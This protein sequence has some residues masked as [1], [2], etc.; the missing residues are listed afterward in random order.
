MQYEEMLS[1]LLYYVTLFQVDKS[2][3]IEIADPV[4]LV[5]SQAIHSAI[6]AFASC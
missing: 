4:G 3:A 6:A 5:Q 1:W 2:A